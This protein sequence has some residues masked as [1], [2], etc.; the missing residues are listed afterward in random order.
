MEPLPDASHGADGERPDQRVGV[1]AVHDEGVD[2]E[3]RR[4][5]LDLGVVHQVEVDELLQL[6]VLRRGGGGGAFSELGLHGHCSLHLIL[7]YHTFANFKILALFCLK[8]SN[9][10]D[11]HR[12]GPSE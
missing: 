3:Q 5:R 10:Q 4:P 9:N 8:T 7:D 6:H 12:T 11:R 1:V 2:D